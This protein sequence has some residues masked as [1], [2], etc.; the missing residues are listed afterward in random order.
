MFLDPKELVIK[1]LSKDDD[2]RWAVANIYG[3][4]EEAV[5]GIF[6]DSLS[7][8]RSLWLVPWCLVGKFNMV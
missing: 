7:S 2:F 1:F 4:N 3:P 5:G 8:I 6:W